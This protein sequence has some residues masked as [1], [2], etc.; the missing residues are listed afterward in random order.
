[1]R[2]MMNYEPEELEGRVVGWRTVYR[3]CPQNIKPGK[4]PWRPRTVW[5][6]VVEAYRD[7]FGI[8]VVTVDMVTGHMQNHLPVADLYAVMPES[9]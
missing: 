7:E 9:Y 5:G 1:M 4:S 3:P 6:R 8:S 2:G